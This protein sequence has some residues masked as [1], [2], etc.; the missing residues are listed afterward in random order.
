MAY[1]PRLWWLRRLVAGGVVLVVAL[2]V[3]RLWWG[4][5]AERRFQRAMERAAAR[6]GPVW[7]HELAPPPLD[8]EQNAAFYLKRAAAAVDRNA[9][10]PANSAIDYDAPYIAHSTGWD[11]MASA[12]VA[13][14]TKVFP[15][16]RRAR[17]VERADWSLPF[18]PAGLQAINP[19]LNNT[20]MLINTVGDAAL[21][22]HEHGDDVAALEAVR[23]ARHAAAAAGS[24]SL[25]VSALVGVGGDAA[26]LSKLQAIAPGLRVAPEDDPA[27]RAANEPRG[28]RSR[29]PAAPPPAA[30]RPVTP[31]NVRELIAELLDDEAPTRRM[32]RG[33]AGERAL[34]HAM[35]GRLAA[36]SWLLRPMWRLD[37]AR[38]VDAYEVII[39]AASRSNLSAS[40][41]VL[42]ASAP[43]MPPAP[44]VP[45]NLFW[46][47]LPAARGA[48]REPVDFPRVLSSS[49]LGGMV[50][51]GRAIE[52]HM[53]VAA[54]RHMVA[55]N[56]GA[57]LYRAEHGQWPPAMESLVP[58]YLP[59][60]PVDPLA[61]GDQP[62][63]YLLVRGGLPD[64][65]D[66]PIVYSAGGN[67]VF[68]TKD[69]PVL[70]NAPIY[71]WFRG[72]D[73]WRDLARWQ[74]LTPGPTSAPSTQPVR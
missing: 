45:V 7:A 32:T 74:P 3:L 20:R 23:D 41:A 36:E 73:E 39:E 46:P 69:P 22:A 37:A 44:K 8:D 71:G 55:V 17:E 11:A 70:P 43:K 40:R 16:V 56:L 24:Q 67:G 68:D 50:S 64:G 61:P 60:A 12:S 48:R 1:P 25:L 34:F 13:A 30:P 28:R 31:Q 29:Y 42:A 58:K 2:V 59:H 49:Y 57:Q 72:A 6:G 19:H 52:Q 62:L 47:P 4:W 54:E 33:Y 65:G 21:Y 53:R 26:A 27:A 10:S 35:T 38:A 5:E 9:W 63:R 66:R 15:L 51:S 18:T 14:N